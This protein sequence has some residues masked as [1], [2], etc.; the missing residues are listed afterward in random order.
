[1][2]DLCKNYL[3]YMHVQ[4]WLQQCVKS[5]PEFSSKVDIPNQFL[6]LLPLPIQTRPVV[7][8]HCNICFNSNDDLSITMRW[9]YLSGNKEYFIIYR[10]YTKGDYTQSNSRE[11]IR[12]ITLSGHVSA[13]IQLEWRE[14]WTRSK[15]AATLKVNHFKT[16][17]EILTIVWDIILFLSLIITSV[18]V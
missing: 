10:M 12:V 7:K 8:K 15:Y 13:T 6:K 5:T 3:F 11:D 14:W 18:W 9:N 4:L 17:L 16:A 1:M 2:K